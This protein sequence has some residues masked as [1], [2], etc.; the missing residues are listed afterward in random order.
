MTIPPDALAPSFAACHGYAVIASDGLCGFVETPLFPP[1]GGEADF[2][3]VRMS[4]RARTRFPIVPVALVEQVD[5][6]SETVNLGLTRAEVRRLP[7]TL[8]LAR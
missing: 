8:P 2:V 4:G 3:V 5:P 1:D 7:E 6:R